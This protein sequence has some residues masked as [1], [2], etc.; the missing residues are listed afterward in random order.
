MEHAERRVQGGGHRAR[1]EYCIVANGTEVFCDG[2]PVEAGGGAGAGGGEDEDE[3]EVD[4][5]RAPTHRR[6]RWRGTITGGHGRG[7]RVTMRG[8]GSWEICR[9]PPV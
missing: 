7:V 8:S 9:A 5:E 4:E 1:H 6:R 2:K 3:E